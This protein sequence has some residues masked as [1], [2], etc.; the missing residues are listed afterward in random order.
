MYRPL[1]L[2][3]YALNFKIHG[4]DP[5]FFR[6]TNLGIHLLNS[7]LVF[8]LVKAVNRNYLVSLAAGSI[9]CV[10]PANAE[11]VNYIS[12]R[13]ESLCALFCLCGLVLYTHARL[14][15]APQIRLVLSVFCFAAALGSKSVAVVV[16]AALLALEV[17]LKRRE[18]LIGILGLCARLHWPFWTLTIA[19]LAV[20]IDLAAEALVFYPVRDLVTQLATQSKALIYYLQLLFIPHNLNVEHQFNLSSSFFE[21]AVI[22]SL[23]VFASCAVI[24]IT[25]K[26]LGGSLFFGQFGRFFFSF[27]QPSSR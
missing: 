6:L 9:F 25:T 7:L 18:S 15:S 4:Y 22:G 5:T 1:V 20:T 24:G 10:H 23:L 14:T 12:A 13:S 19:Y 8:H 17:H 3:T 21:F 27:P 26:R 2:L 16:P 11:V